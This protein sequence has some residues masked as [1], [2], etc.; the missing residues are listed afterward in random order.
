MFVVHFFS[1]L[2]YLLPHSFGPS[3][4]S[5]IISQSFIFLFALYLYPYLCSKWNVFFLSPPTD[6]S[7]LKSKSCL[8]SIKKQLLYP[9]PLRASPRVYPYP[10]THTHTH[11]RDDIKCP[12]Y[13]SSEQSGLTI[14]YAVSNC[15]L[16]CLP[17]M[18]MD[19]LLAGTLSIIDF[20]CLRFWTS[21]WHYRF[22]KYI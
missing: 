5:F 7:T 18:T 15:L 12:C 1:F 22:S 6:L 20:L 16:V 9:S 17:Y 3:S 21:S 8:P 11:F 10:L 4:Q 14:W 13:L 2:H 19:S